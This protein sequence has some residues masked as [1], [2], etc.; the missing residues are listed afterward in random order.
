MTWSH[1]AGPRC[2]H[3][4][5]VTDESLPGLQEVPPGFKPLSF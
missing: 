3:G 4:V 5:I 2:E 1:D